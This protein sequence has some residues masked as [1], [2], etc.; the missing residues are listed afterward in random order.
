VGTTLATEAPNK[1]GR[2]GVRN[3]PFEFRREIAWLAREPGISVTGL[4]MEHGLNT[5]P[6]FSAGR[7]TPVD[8]IPL[9]CFP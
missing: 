4:A 1:S 6:V 3:Q 5:S 7:C 9:V 8:T 2:K